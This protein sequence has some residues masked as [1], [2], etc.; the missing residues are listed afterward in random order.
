MN[1]SMHSTKVVTAHLNPSKVGGKLEAA[2]IVS[3]HVISNDGQKC[4][5]RAIKSK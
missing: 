2:I 1:A 4:E 3:F 5:E